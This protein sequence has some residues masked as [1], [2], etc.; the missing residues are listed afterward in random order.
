MGIITGILSTS[1]LTSLGLLLSLF[2]TAIFIAGFF[3]I[4]TSITNEN[5][6][7]NTDQNNG[8]KVENRMITI[9][10]QI[11]NLNSIIL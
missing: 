11:I 7:V 2:D 5:T 6:P 3:L 1:G 9:K 10:V 8:I 4:F